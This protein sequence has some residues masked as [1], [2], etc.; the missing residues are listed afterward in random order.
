MKF[1]DEEQ[2]LEFYLKECE[3]ENKKLREKVERYEN[4]IH[5]IANIDTIFYNPDGTDREWDDKE[6]L[7][8]I[9]NMVMPIWNK[10]CEESWERIKSKFSL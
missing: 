10:H 1:D 7:R 6:A 9:E 5:A 8:E 3:E 4:I 2:R